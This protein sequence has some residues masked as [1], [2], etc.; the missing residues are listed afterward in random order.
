MGW[1]KGRRGG[2]IRGKL[3]VGEWH[4]VGGVLQ[5][6]WNLLLKKGSPMSRNPERIEW[7]TGIFPFIGGRKPGEG[8]RDSSRRGTVE[9]YRED[10]S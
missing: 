7:A 1:E 3:G 5:K 9:S 10:S 8:E 2:C 6:I 4:M